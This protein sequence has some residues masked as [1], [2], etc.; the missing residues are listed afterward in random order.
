MKNFAYMNNVVPM[1]LFFNSI[2][3]RKFMIFKCSIFFVIN[4]DSKWKFSDFL[5]YSSSKMC[6]TIKEDVHFCMF[7]CF[8]FS[9]IWVIKIQFNNWKLSA[10]Q[11]FKR[12]NRVYR[13]V[14]LQFVTVLWFFHIQ[15]FSFFFFFFFNILYFVI[16]AKLK[17]RKQ[18]QQQQCH[19]NK[20]YEKEIPSYFIL[21]FFCH[22]VVEKFNKI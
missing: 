2:Y 15:F 9:F 14:W 3:N 6:L 22:T 18:E 5:L 16:Y 17:R 12:S 8:I 4:C 11:N 21:L 10:W 13:N 7:F 1:E 19:N 20:K